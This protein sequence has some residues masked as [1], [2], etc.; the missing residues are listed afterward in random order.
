MRAP[1]VEDPGRFAF[2]DSAKPEPEM[3]RPAVITP[4]T[5]QSPRWAAPP[6][7][8][9]VLSDLH[10]GAP[11]TSLGQLETWI[12][13]TNALRADLIVLAGDFLMDRFM[14]AFSRHASAAQICT[15]LAA[16]S[17]PSGCGPCWAIT[18]GLIAILPARARGRET[19]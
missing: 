13:Q 16:L 15:R 12:A 19:R 6:V 18:I 11:W 8:I 17:A 10:I 14:W 9:A 1:R 3:P 7:R 2:A 5:L 4:Y